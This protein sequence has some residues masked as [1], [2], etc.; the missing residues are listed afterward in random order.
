MLILPQHL[1]EM[2]G[3]EKRRR[4]LVQYI[5]DTWHI[6]EPGEF[7]DGRHIEAL[8]IHLEAVSRREIRRLIVNIPPR[9]MKSVQ[10]AVMWPTWHWL[11]EPTYKLLTGSY[12][13][14]LAVRD[15][16][17]SRDI[18]NSEFYKKTLYYLDEA[19]PARKAWKLKWD[20]NV[21]SRYENTLGGSRLTYSIGGQVTGDGGDAVLMDDPLSAKGGDSKAKLE[22]ATTF[23]DRTLST[24]LNDRRSGA[25]ILIMQRLHE[26]DVT[27]HILAQENHGYDHL[28]LP[29]EFSPK[30]TLGNV[31]FDPRE[32][33]TSIGW[34]DWRTEPG[35]LLW[36]DRLGHAEVAELKRDLGP[37]GYSGQAQQTPSPLGGGM[38][39]KKFWKYYDSLPKR[40]DR[41]LQ[42]WDCSF[43]DSDGSDFVCGTVWGWLG[44]DSYLIDIVN[45]RMDINLTCL[46]IEL[47][48][49]AY[50]QAR[51]KLV[52]DKANGPAVIQLLKRK[53]VGLIAVE[54][55]GSKET[56]VS[57]CVPAQVAGNIHLPNPSKYPKLAK[58]VLWFIEQC[59]Q[60]PKGTHD[61]MVDSFTQAHIWAWD[62]GQPKFHSAK[63]LRAAAKP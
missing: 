58:Q 24:R 28:F 63:D 3:A 20:Q 42:S 23:W 26:K 31:T 52:E 13:E 50:P 10:C 5:K 15:A 53:I 39:K 60:F 33:P 43:K 34:I 1:P 16:V 45:D 12:A 38:L 37:Y 35:E 57:A 56:R 61:D 6:V 9:T 47:M 48:S 29:M 4:S 21:K 46:A 25:R 18:L 51:A 30:V 22:E 2:I 49:S 36:P 54:P 62:N 11:S 14:E 41:V 7:Q 27:G 19:D 40:F 55:Y 8:A 44:A 17:K 32:R 59:G